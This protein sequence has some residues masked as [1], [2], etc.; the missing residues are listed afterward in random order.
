[1]SVV[2]DNAE[3]IRAPC[4][5]RQLL[6]NPLLNKGTAFSTEERVELGM[7]GLLPPRVST[8]DEQLERCYQAY[9]EKQTDLERHIYLRALQDRNETL[10]YALVSHKLVEMLPIIYTPTVGLACQRF[11]QIYR[12]YRGL[13]VP[14]PERGSIDR[15]LE[16]GACG[17]H[18][19]VIV[20]TDAARILGLGDQGA[21]G[22]GI[23]IGKLSLY[24]VCGGIDPA[25]TL[26]VLLDVG[27]DNAERLADPLYVGWRH[28]RIRGDEYEA[29]V[30]Q[31]VEGIMRHFP[32]AILQWED[33]AQ[34]N[35][36]QLLERYRDRLCTFND[37]IQGTAAVTLGA[38]LSAADIVATPLQKQWIVI[39]GAGSAGCG[40]AHQLS[41]AMQNAGL[42][43]P[44]ACARIWLINRKGL[45]TDAATDPTPEQ[46]PFLKPTALLDGW[47]EDAGGHVGLEP[48]VRQVRPTILIGVSG[49]G[50]AFTEEVIRE[51]ASHVE[52]P[53]I[54]PLSNPTSKAEV[55]PEWVMAWSDG[56]AVVATGSPFPDLEQG[57]VQ[58]PVAQCNNAYIFPGIGL[59]VLAVNGTRISDAMFTTAA[60]ALAAFPKEDPRAVLPS[61]EQIREVSVVIAT[62]VA[63]RAVADG[64]GD[65]IAD[66]EIDKRIEE[67]LWEPRYKP[68]RLASPAPPPTR[69]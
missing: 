5:G 21:G 32:N 51:M 17:R 18:I 22:M 63:R 6:S 29:F 27:T 64:L 58:R 44:E 12:Q 23:P 48:V 7:E 57:G 11:S 60:R 62:A 3:V 65:W 20:V 25:T 8:L 19:E 24:T 13:F 42:S 66:E 47:G 45:L 68:V 43:E 26:P 46:R 67:R 35:A 41:L 10:F 4:S 40:I 15:I 28:P 49:Q 39:F 16:N 53:V 30:E 56:R 1:M 55:S 69:P 14:W 59:G 61:L 54:F 31:F 37:D 2:D 9:Q 50:G 52:H 33:F 36:A 34:P 38:L